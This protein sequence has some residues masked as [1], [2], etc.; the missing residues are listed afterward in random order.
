MVKA[1]EQ[2]EASSCSSYL[3][4]HNT[5][6]RSESQNKL[7][8]RPLAQ[9]TGKYS[10]KT[11]CHHVK[12]GPNRAAALSPNGRTAVLFKPRNPFHR[13]LQCEI[14]RKQSLTM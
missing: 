9:A 10:A 3:G 11:S 1:C 14:R 13:L 7:E 6:P 8:L 5:T 4:S 2:R 12:Q